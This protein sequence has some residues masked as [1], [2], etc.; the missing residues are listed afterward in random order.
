M[1]DEVL[2]VDI[3]DLDVAVR[4]VLPPFRLL[5][6]KPQRGDDVGY[7]CLFERLRAP[8]GKYSLV[9]SADAD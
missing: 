5:V 3:V 9:R 1:L 2:I 8:K 7:A 6:V 4:V